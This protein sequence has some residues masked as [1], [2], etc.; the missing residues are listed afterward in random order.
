MVVQIANAI[1]LFYYFVLV[2]ARHDEK[3]MSEVVSS[4]TLYVFLYRKLNIV[5]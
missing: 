1:A 2:M 4:L 3:L 5:T